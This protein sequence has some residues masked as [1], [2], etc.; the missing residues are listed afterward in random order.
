M[1]VVLY[2]N[3][4]D[5]LCFLNIHK[6]TEESDLELSRRALNTPMDDSVW[7]DREQTSFERGR[8]DAVYIHTCMY[9]HVHTYKADCLS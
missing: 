8:K 4:S 9:I 2:Y 5:C 1:S 3:I 6:D 7:N